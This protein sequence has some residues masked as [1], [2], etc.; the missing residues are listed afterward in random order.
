MDGL[1]TFL[2]LQ[3]DFGCWLP[4]VT[5]ITKTILAAGCNDQRLPVFVVA[6][7]SVR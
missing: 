6:T 1:C 7:D 3:D 2:Q 4:L 5:C